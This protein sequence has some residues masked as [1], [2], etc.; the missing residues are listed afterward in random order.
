[1]HYALF[2]KILKKVFKIFTEP[3]KNWV[4]KS[5]SKNYFGYFI[6]GYGYLPW[7]TLTW[8]WSGVELGNNNV[9]LWWPEDED[10]F[11][12]T[13]TDMDILQ[14]SSLSIQKTKTL[15]DENLTWLLI[16]MVCRLFI[17]ETF[18]CQLLRQNKKMTKNIIL[19]QLSGLFLKMN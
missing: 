8:F 18:T 6:H 16:S 4:L 7:L 19:H 3:P 15:E 17:F 5:L 2:P 11:I 12:S 9:Q 10:V 1:M 14:W 13:Q